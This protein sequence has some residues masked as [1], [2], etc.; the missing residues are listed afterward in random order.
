MICSKFKAS[1]GARVLLTYI[2]IWNNTKIQTFEQ[3]SVW[4]ELQPETMT[5]QVETNDEFDP[6]HGSRQGN[7]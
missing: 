1:L 4:D 2:E 6:Q 3:E 7:G 5:Q